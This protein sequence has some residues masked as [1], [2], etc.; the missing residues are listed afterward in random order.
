MIGEYITLR[1]K[2]PYGL[3]AAGQSA[4]F[5]PAVAAQLIADGIAEPVDK[6]A[7][8]ALEEAGSS[9][10]DAG[11]KTTGE[12]AE[13]FPSKELLVA[14]GISTYEE[15]AQNLAG[16]SEQEAL[17]YLQQFEGI[18]KATAKKIYAAAPKPE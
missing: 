3:I 6:A 15:L 17:A 7:A 11:V 4:S 9:E 12:L 10:A 1:L 2:E 14:C 8:A 16:L 18:G 5:Q 13:D